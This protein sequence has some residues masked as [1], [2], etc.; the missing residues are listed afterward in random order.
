MV[1][2]IIK[3]KCG[4]LLKHIF[5]SNFY[6]VHETSPMKIEP[7]SVIKQKQNDEIEISNGV[8]AKLCKEIK[9]LNKTIKQLKRSKI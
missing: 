2:N 4:T 8:I 7:I 1:D 9:E 6:F 5:K 3:N